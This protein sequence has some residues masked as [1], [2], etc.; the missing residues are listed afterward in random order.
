M[1]NLGLLLLQCFTFGF[2]VRD[3]ICNFNW[4]QIPVLA[5]LG[6]LIYFNLKIN[7]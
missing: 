6:I 5:L 1:S 4:L 3:L 2:C 7:D